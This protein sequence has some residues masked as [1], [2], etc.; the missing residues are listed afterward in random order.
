[1]LEASWSH[2]VQ[3]CA[4]VHSGVTVSATIR[5]RR[6]VCCR[7]VLEFG[8]DAAAFGELVFENDEVARGLDEV[9]V[10]ELP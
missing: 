7:G 10:R 2:C 8:V 9:I 5:L 1:M 4:S 6:R 3:A